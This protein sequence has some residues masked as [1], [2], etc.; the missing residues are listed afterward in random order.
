MN[1]RVEKNGP[2]VTVIIDR[3][4]V[5]NAV[6]G[7]TA[8]E[9]FDAFRS[10]DADPAASVAVLLGAGGSFC[11][12][13]DLKALSEPGLPRAN[14]LEAD[15][16]AVAPMGPSRMVLGKPVIAAVGGFA[17][18]GGLELAIWCDL[19]VVEED[20]VFGVYCRRYGVPLID[21]GTVRLARLVGLSR[22]MDMVLT[23]RSVPA[24]EAYNMGLAN[25]LVPPGKSR[26][27][28]EK[29]AAEISRWPQACMRNDR[30]AMLAGL[31]MP[32]GQAMENEFA[33]GM[34]TIRSGE[35]LSGAG[36]FAAGKD[37]E[38]P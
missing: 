1:V 38:R 35:T 33:V 15:M 6:D 17:V 26:E 34:E 21:G 19:R 12:G 14:P 32:Y 3:P 7:P 22:A 24:R 11:A 9:L 8:R 37:R 4:D 29:L 5:K 28:A 18:A 2:V 13:A 25:R 36:R 27:E 30:A 16:N 20:A 31:S 10:F 23:G